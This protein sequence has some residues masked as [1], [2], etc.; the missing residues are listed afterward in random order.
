MKGKLGVLSQPLEALQYTPA[1]K[2]PSGYN[3]DKYHPPRR[4]IRNRENTM[5]LQ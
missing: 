3:P 4:Y 5:F 1:A 2:L